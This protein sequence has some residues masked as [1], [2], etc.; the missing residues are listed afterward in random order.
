MCD[1]VDL[2]ESE[3]PLVFELRIRSLSLGGVATADAEEELRQMP[4]QD[5]GVELR[6]V[7]F[8]SLLISVV[9]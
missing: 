5:S 8:T 4:R 6:G 3:G 9:I 1:V 7:R 2:D